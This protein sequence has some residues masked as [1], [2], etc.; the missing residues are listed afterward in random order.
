MRYKRRGSALID[1]AACEHSLIFTIQFLTSSQLCD[2]IPTLRPNVG[3]GGIIP[4]NMF[5]P[6]ISVGLQVR[7]SDGQ[8]ATGEANRG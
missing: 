6:G 4:L 7:E 1:S 5:T 2:A 3:G 8:L